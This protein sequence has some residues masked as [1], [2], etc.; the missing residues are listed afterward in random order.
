MAPPQRTL[1]PE[2]PKTGA[3]PSQGCTA[4][5]RGHQGGTRRCWGA[6]IPGLR[7]R[8]GR[9]TSGVRRLEEARATGLA[10]RDPYSR[11]LTRLSLRSSGRA[12]VRSSSLPLLGWLYNGRV[13]A[14]CCVRG[15]G[16]RRAWRTMVSPNPR[17]PFSFEPLHAW[18]VWC[19][20]ACVW[21]VYGR[22]AVSVVVWLVFGGVSRRMVGWIARWV[23]CAAAG[24]SLSVS[25]SLWCW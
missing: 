21:S 23:C 24:V 22:I 19:L 10:C 20:P 14:V 1:S 7:G 3:R 16:R 25:V 12:G 9:K 6:K 15:C 17:T 11:L 18:L 5:A 4:P 2:G 8:D 13:V